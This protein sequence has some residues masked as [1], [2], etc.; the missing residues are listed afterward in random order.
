VPIAAVRDAVQQLCEK[1]QAV[2]FRSYP[3]LDHDP[4]MQRSTPDQLE[5]I[6]ARFS[7]KPAA[8]TCAASAS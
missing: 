8:S 4:T 5:W 7:G 3:G 6:R 1:K 2:T